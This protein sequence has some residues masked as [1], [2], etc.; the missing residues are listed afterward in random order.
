MYE[1]TTEAQVPGAP[2][3]QTFK[4]SDNGDNKDWLW[5]WL[6]AGGPWRGGYGGYGAGGGCAPNCNSEINQ[7]EFDGVMAALN[8]L[9]ADL[10]ANRTATENA[11]T[12]AAIRQIQDLFVNLNNQG[13]LN[14]C[15]RFHDLSRQIQQCCCDLKQQIC[16]VKFEMAQGFSGVENAICTQTQT[17]QHQAETNTRDIIDAV[18]QE[19]QLTRSQMADQVLAETRD[20]LAAAEREL[21]EER[22]IN[23]ITQA[24]GCCPGGNGN[25]HHGGH[26][27]P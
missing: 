18:R 15:N 8:G 4:D 10:T 24:C 14:N 5:A 27:R 1:K 26:H 13:E 20:K 12:R 16:D 21:G 9:R 7:R 22:V 6:F 25:G 3:F 2:I 23:R 11:E 19:G 17:L